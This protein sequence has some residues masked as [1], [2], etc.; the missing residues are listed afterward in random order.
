M[1][2]RLKCIFYIEL[3]TYYLDSYKISIKN[4]QNKIPIR[5]S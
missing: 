1:F 2:G 5:I 4:K 3:L